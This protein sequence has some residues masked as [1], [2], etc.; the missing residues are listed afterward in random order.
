MKRLDVLVQCEGKLFLESA[1]GHKELAISD[2]DPMTPS[3]HATPVSRDL[4]QL[5]MI[6]KRPGMY[7]GWGDEYGLLGL[8]QGPHRPADRGGPGRRLP[9]DRSG[10]AR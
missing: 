9:L 1:R 7:L 3:S 10:S 5:A 6:R 8:N 2:T 4:D